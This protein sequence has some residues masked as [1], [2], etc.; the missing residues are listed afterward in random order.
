[1]VGIIYS[2]IL[3]QDQITSTGDVMRRLQQPMKLVLKSI[4]LSSKR[5]INARA[6]LRQPTAFVSVAIACSMLFLA[7]CSQPIRPASDL[8]PATPVIPASTTQLVVVVS[9]SWNASSGQLYQFSRVAGQPWQSTGQTSQV[10]LGRNG[11]AWGL[12]LHPVQSGPQKQEGDGK[13][14]AGLFRLSAAFGAL[15]TLATQMPYQQMSRF[16][17]CIDVPASP[18]YNQTLDIRQ[19]RSEWTAG[20]SEPMRRDL[21]AKPDAVYEQG[22]F[23]DHNFSS[24]EAR[25]TGAGSC[26]FM[27]LK[28]PDGRKTAG[29]TALVPEH[30]SALLQWLTPQAEPLY[31]LVPASEYQRLQQ[32]WLL[33]PLP[34]S[35]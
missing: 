22:L 32:D 33:P 19:Y 29:C 34:T 13:A 5:M 17:Y 27:H 8:V 7:A 9:D 30:L 20:S 16:D 21:M 15:P 28:S 1:V 24:G 25:Q 2:S 10:D 23:I 4:V 14:P 3:T 31:L 12:G 26:I 6:I 35:R 18:L 11:T